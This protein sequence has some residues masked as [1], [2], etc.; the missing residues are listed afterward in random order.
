MPAVVTMTMTMMLMMARMMA[1]VVMATGVV[2][3]CRLFD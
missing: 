2:T 1:V 3:R